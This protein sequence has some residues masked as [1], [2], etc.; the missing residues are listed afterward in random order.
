MDEKVSLNTNAL[1]FICCTNIIPS[2]KDFNMEEFHYIVRETE[3]KI[4]CCYV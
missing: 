1:T 4:Y 2:I 3:G